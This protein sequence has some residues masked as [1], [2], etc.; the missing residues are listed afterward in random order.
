M[1]TLQWRL[2]PRLKGKRFLLSE[3]PNKA[4]LLDCVILIPGWQTQQT[5]STIKL[6]RVYAAL[7]RNYS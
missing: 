5:V 6:M 4:V 3:V 2:Q 1:M 7:H